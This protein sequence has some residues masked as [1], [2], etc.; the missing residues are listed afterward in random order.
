MI[1]ETNKEFPKIENVKIQHF[2][3]FFA[4]KVLQKNHFIVMIKKKE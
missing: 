1:L 2:L 3:S 4:K